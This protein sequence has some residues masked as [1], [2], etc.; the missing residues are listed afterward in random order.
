M[1]V[2]SARRRILRQLAGV[3]AANAA[4]ILGV[5]L[6]A[7]VSLNGADYGAFSLQY[8]TL[9]LASAVTMS[10]LCDAYVRAEVSGRPTATWPDY[11]GV[12]VYLSLIFGLVTLLLSV[13][14]PVLRPVAA[15]GALAVAA[16]TYRVGARFR[17]LRDRTAGAVVLG[18]S[19]GFV[20][21]VLAWVLV[22]DD[23][24]RGLT[25]VTAI[26]A[27]S[28][29]CTAILSLAPVWRHP[30]VLVS[31]VR[32]YRGEIRSLL[33]ESGLL[34]IG[35][36]ATPYTLAPLLGLTSFATYRA[37]VSVAAPVRF[38][39]M[40]ARPL[41]SSLRL[42]RMRS[43]AVVA[44]N[45]AASAVLGVAAFA[46]LTVVNRSSWELGVLNSASEFSEA[47]G[48]F[49]AATY[50]STFYYFAARTHVPGRALLAARL[51]QTLLV[52]AL[53]LGGVL[54]RNLSGAMWGLAVGT[55]LSAFVWIVAVL[56]LSHDG[57]PDTGDDPALDSLT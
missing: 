1:A 12:L 57:R 10:V 18:D 29:I 54:L 40:P 30:S 6:L 32:T 43:A 5:Q 3:T 51:V 20:A 23:W 41:V 24:R 55:A 8:L 9:A 21:L 17:A 33:P 34:Y 7:L 44:A 47:I 45:G 15:T 14:V 28:A 36:I 11:S 56:G 48:V 46:A 2:S 50:L 35:N 37:S 13:A 4:Y 26:W 25:G 39:L 27:V 52:T 22:P 49:V 38:I 31:W 19:S 53:P 42:A 16:T